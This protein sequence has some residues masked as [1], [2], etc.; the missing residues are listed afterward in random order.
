LLA[1]A[2]R[3]VVAFLQRLFL[4][5]EYACDDVYSGLPPCGYAGLSATPPQPPAGC[6]PRGFSFTGVAA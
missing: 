4:D 3:V 1:W 5:C 2:H 6:D